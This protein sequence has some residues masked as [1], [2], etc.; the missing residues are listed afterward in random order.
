MILVTLGTQ[1]QSFNR[2]LDMIEKSNINDKI[3][4]QAGYTK[5][6]SKK[7]KMLDFVNYQE[8]DKLI[9]QADLIIT[10]GGTGSIV[11]AIKQ[12]KK[13]IAC[14]RLK[15]YG[16]HVDD[17]Q[18]QIVDI[19]SEVGYILKL[20]ENDNLDELVQ[21]IKTKKMIPFKSNTTNFINNLKKE[22]DC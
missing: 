3:I 2:L 21:K 16:E 20:D 6:K 5:Y 8:M 13:V 14:P 12:G 9:K 18:K 22:I 19:F 11:T 15:K 1:K 17:H 4:V 10:H 7:M